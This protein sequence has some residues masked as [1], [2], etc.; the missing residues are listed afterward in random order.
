MDTKR[1]LRAAVSALSEDTGR[2]LSVCRKVGALERTALLDTLRGLNVARWAVIVHR[3]SGDPAYRDEFNAEDVKR[4][5]ALCHDL[6][7]EVA[8]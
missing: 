5:H 6:L 4:A 3:L 8:A 2:T 7:T 1:N